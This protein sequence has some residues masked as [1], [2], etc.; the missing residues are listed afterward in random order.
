MRAVQEA[1][2]P[3]DFPSIERD[4]TRRI[5]P[6]PT[7]RPRSASFGDLVVGRHPSQRLQDIG[8]RTEAFLLEYSRIAWRQGAN[9]CDL[10]FPERHIGNTFLDTAVLPCL[11]E[12]VVEFF[13]AEVDDC[14]LPTFPHRI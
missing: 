9:D 14:F 10:S 5:G 8:N 13:E 4:G 11:S 6:R 3:M 1:H 2:Q 7:A 12:F